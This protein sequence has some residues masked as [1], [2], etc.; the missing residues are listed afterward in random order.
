MASRT[1]A[2]ILDQHSHEIPKR[3]FICSSTAFGILIAEG[4]RPA[5][6]INRLISNWVYGGFLAGILILSL[7]PV[8]ARGWHAALLATFL[9]LPVYMVHQYEEH[10]KDRFRSFVNR[11]LGNGREVLTPLAVFITNIIG[12]WAVLALAF[13]LTANVDLGYG[14]IAAYLLLLN[15]IIHIAQAIAGRGYNPGLITALVLFL[16]MGAYC[17]CSVQASGSATPLMHGIGAASAIA[18]HTAIA[19][20]VLYKRST[21]L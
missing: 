14:L 15:A 2:F 5:A 9:C 19:T 17:L 6:M 20:Q 8:L 18:V 12:V 13:W 21:L 16:P 4:A 10:D 3:N 11:I 7:T 1:P